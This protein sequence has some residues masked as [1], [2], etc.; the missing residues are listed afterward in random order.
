MLVTRGEL[1]TTINN[2]C[3]CI[4]IITSLRTLQHTVEGGGIAPV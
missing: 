2:K 4:Y 3:I 1:I